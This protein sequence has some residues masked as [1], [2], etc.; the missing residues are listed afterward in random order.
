MSDKVNQLLKEGESHSFQNNCVVK[1]YGTYG[2]LSPEFQSWV[3]EVEDFISS[4]FGES[5]S[6]WRLFTRFNIDAVNGNEQD[7]FEENKRSII[8]ALKSCLRVPKREVQAV[9]V[10]LNVALEMLFDRFH[11]VVKQLRHRYNSRNTLD[12]EDE[13]DVQDLLHA[14]LRIYF[15]DIRNEEWAPSYAGGSSRMDFL[16][17]AEKTVIEVKKTRKGLGDRELGK[18]LVEDKAKYKAHPDCERLV[19]FVYDPDGR[20]VNPRGIERDL[21]SQEEGFNVLVV[22]KP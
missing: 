5:S 10:G 7:A 14:L 18:Q 2:R 8:A 11:L 22:I 9:S 21:N 15:E 1:E 17:K 19:C 3:A 13:Y 20:I 12:V 4:N 16:L 6:P